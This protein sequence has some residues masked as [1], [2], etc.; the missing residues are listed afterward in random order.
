MSIIRTKFDGHCQSC[1]AEILTGDKVNWVKGIKGVTCASCPAPGTPANGTP[2]PALTAQA[3]EIAR[4]NEALTLARQTFRQQREEI[5][6]LTTERDGARMYLTKAITDKTDAQNERD[7]WRRMH[8]ELQALRVSGVFA[9]VE[10]ASHAVAPDADDD[11][12]I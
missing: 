9:L 11:C 10:A 4:L 6:A 2:A 5:A 3:A 12:P 8:D 7:H 1:N